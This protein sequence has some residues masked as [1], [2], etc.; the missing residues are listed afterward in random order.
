[1]VIRNQRKV[2]AYIIQK[3][4]HVVFA[5]TLYMGY[6]PAWSCYGRSGRPLVAKLWIFH[7]QTRMG[8]WREGGKELGKE[9]WASEELLVWNFTTGG[10]GRRSGQLYVSP[11][12]RI[13]SCIYCV[14]IQLYIS[15][16]NNYTESR[17]LAAATVAR[18]FY[19][20]RAVVVFAIYIAVVHTWSFFSDQWRL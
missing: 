1:M 9:H 13:S 16:G 17:V 6:V 2:T 10:C 8:R 7:W 5:N 15:K 20:R 12:G 11:W 19:K 18:R 14:C 3:I 4:Q